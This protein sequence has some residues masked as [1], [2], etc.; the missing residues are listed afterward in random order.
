[1]TQTD[2]ILDHL[3]SGPITPLDAEK[4]PIRCRRLAARIFELK[5]RGHH[6]HTEIRRDGNTTWAEYH[7]VDRPQQAE[8]W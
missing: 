4:P 2:A 7:L 8:M 5:Q 6:I 3:R 1:M